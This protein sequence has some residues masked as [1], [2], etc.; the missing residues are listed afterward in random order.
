MVSSPNVLS[1]YLYNMLL[2]YIMLLL[3]IKVLFCLFIFWCHL[4][5]GDDFGGVILGELF[6]NLSSE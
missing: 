5:E 4:V 2:I 6:E 1:I 3:Y